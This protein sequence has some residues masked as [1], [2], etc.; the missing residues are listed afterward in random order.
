MQFNKI[1]WIYNSFMFACIKYL[2]ATVENITPD[3]NW[4]ESISVLSCTETELS[5]RFDDFYEVKKLLDDSFYLWLWLK[6]VCWG[7]SKTV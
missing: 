1:Y 2:K 5:R 3:Q 7:V 6:E 4:I